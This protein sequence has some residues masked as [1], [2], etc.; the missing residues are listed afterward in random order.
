MSE[1][2]GLKIE[3]I[4]VIIQ[5][6]KRSIVAQTVTDTLIGDIFQ[7]KPLINIK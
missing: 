6:R 3:S 4:S 5:A 7:N 1:Y 2:T